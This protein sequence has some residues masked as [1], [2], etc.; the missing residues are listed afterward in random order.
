MKRP[1]LVGIRHVALF[2][3]ELEACERFWVEVM[4][5]Q[6]EW[7]PDGDNVYLSSGSDNLAM[8]RKKDAA[9]STWERLDHVGLAVLSPEL[10]DAWAEHLEGEGVTLQQAPKTHRDGA[11]SLYFRDPGGTLVQIIHHAP[12]VP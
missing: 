12:L 11:R 5:Y 4:G 7:K 8:H 10:V 9:V 1:P 3:P 2:V 6:V